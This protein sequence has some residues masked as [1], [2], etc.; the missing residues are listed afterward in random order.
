MIESHDRDIGESAQQRCEWADDYDL[1]SQEFCADPFS[2]W[3]TMRQAC[4]IAHSDLWGGSWMPIHYN[5]IRTIARDS[6][7]FSSRAVEVAGP[8]PEQGGG[9]FAPPL[10]SDPPEHYSHRNLLQPFFTPQKLAELEPFIRAEARSLVNT[11]AERGAGDAVEDFAQ[12]LTIAVLARLLDVPRDNEQ[13]FTDWVVRLV[14]IGP[15]DQ[16]VRTTAVR[17]ILDYCDALLTERRRSPG[18]DLVSYLATTHIDGQELR[19][20]HQ[21]GSC[22]LILLAGAD[23]TW[24]VIGASLWHLATHPEDR[25]RL[26]AEP[27]LPG[28]AVE[29]LLRVYAPVTI[30]RIA[31][32]RVELHSR[33][34]QAGERIILPFAAA[35]R[36]PKQFVDPNIVKLDRKPNLHLTFGSG[37]HRCLGAGLATIEL[38]VALEEWLRVIPDF[39]LVEP[40]SIQ[41]SGGQVRGPE[42]VMFQV[43]K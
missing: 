42:R 1:F 13:R 20:K 22:L 10:T 18:D 23:T 39:S 41:W 35:N 29:E 9:L 40:D 30:A 28:R 15:R 14:R 26:T 43:K 25:A 11:L 17:E 19:R 16:A 34:I 5:D 6:Q 32:D 21:L 3:D 36:D 38:R 24:S 4:P 7:R 27:E 33:S 31:K 2:R 8:I 37:G 12:H